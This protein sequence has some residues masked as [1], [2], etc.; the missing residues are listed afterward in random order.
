MPLAVAPSLPGTLDIENPDHV[1]GSRTHLPTRPCAHRPATRFTPCSAGGFSNPQPLAFRT[2]HGDCI[3]ILLLQRILW[4]RGVV[5]L[6]P[7]S[8]HVFSSASPL[9]T[10]PVL[11]PDRSGEAFC[12]GD[13][14][15]LD[16]R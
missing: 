1:L 12:S 9:P 4:A 6:L 14:M 2:S 11:I 13:L 7:A 16:V 15:V 5:T 10:P 3:T 8:S